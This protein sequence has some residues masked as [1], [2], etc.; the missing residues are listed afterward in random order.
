MSFIR[1]RVCRWCSKL[2]NEPLETSCTS[3]GG[4][5]PALPAKLLRDN[6]ELVVTDADFAAI[7]PGG[8]PRK[9]PAGYFSRHLIW[10]NFGCLWGSVWMAI[11]ALFLVISFPLLFVFLPL[12]VI[13]FLVS[14]LVIGIGV[15]ATLAGMMSPWKKLMALRS[16]LHA[17]GTVVDVREGPIDLG[18]HGVRITYVFETP[19]G[20]SQGVA[21]TADWLAGQR[22]EGERIWV[23][24]RQG[25][26]DQ[27]AIWPPV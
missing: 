15:V 24:Y 26:P 14:L 27:N 21:T 25:R 22:E 3:C 18:E 6:P 17:Q 7:A 11:G 9:L 19:S 20:M 8:R 4:P 2:S 16:G 23:V 1:Q 12:G 5:L 10:S 13:F